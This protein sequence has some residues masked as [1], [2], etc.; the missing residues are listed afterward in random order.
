M[1]FEANW[2]AD[3]LRDLKRFCELNKLPE[4][5]A[6]LEVTIDTL[7]IELR[8]HYKTASVPRNY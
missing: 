8:T 3:I 6:S 2:M 4:T 5:V 1:S 7:E